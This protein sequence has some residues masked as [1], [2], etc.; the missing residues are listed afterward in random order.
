[1]WNDKNCMALI[2]LRSISADDKTVRYANELFSNENKFSFYVSVS[3]RNE[4]G[5]D[6]K[7][8]GESMRKYSFFCVIMLCW[9]EARRKQR[10]NWMI[11]VA[12]MI[13]HNLHRSY[14]MFIRSPSDETL[15]YESINSTL[16]LFPAALLPPRQRNLKCLNGMINS[17][18]NTFSIS[19]FA[20]SVCG[21]VR[22]REMK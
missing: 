12:T 8:E 4:R 20:G 2:S 1:M 5:E 18:T 3:V 14:T 15:H 11:D 19:P 16:V 6:G 7:S 21:G 17:N 9:G 13:S 10:K 22:A